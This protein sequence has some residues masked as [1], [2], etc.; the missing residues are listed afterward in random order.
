MSLSLLAKAS[1]EAIVDWAAFRLLSRAATWSVEWW[2]L[3][4][5]PRAVAT[6][7][8]GRVV[9]SRWEDNAEQHTFYQ[10]RSNKA[11]RRALLS[12]LE[13]VVAGDGGDGET[14]DTDDQGDGDDDN[15]W[16]DACW[17]DGSQVEDDSSEA[18]RCVCSLSDGGVASVN[19]WVHDANASLR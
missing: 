3:V 8:P 19:L 11:A 15:A 2:C 10:P 18:I 16:A 4:D 14:G 7:R 5:S 1:P 13:D 12:A 6:F 17:D 9:V